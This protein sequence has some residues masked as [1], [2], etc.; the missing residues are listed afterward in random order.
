MRGAEGLRFGLRLKHGQTFPH[1]V[2][3]IK[4]VILSFGTF[5]KVKLYKARHLVEMT[6]ARRATPP[7]KP[8]R[9]VESALG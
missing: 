3:S 8:Q 9:D 6:V 5:E 7:R 4:R 2:G 1:R